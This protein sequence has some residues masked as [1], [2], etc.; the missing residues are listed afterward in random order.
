MARKVV[1][2][3]YDAYGGPEVAKIAP[4][5]FEAGPTDPGEYRVAYCS[6]HASTRYPTWS[7]IP[8]GAPLKDE[9]G[10]VWVKY[11]GTWQPLST[12]ATV[13]RTDVVKYHQ[14]LYGVAKVPASWVFNDFGHATCFL[15]R[16]E[17]RNRRRDPKEKIHS[18]FLHTTPVAEAVEALGGTSTLVESH[19]C[20]HLKP[21]QMDDMIR[22]GFL[23]KNVKVIFHRYSDRKVIFPKSGSG[24]GP[25]VLHF[26]PSMLQ[27]LVIGNAK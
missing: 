23:R 24:I 19:G 3:V 10:V 15:Y 17:N 11:Q 1:V 8:W 25:F 5:G 4:D 16:D 27:I 21:G 26:F 22:R 2:Q 7:K 12:V 9:K 20:V 13:T 14:E 6:R 18:E